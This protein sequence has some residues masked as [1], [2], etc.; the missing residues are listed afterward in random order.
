LL[1]ASSGA[2]AFC[3]IAAVTVLGPL[4]RSGEA[5]CGAP[6]CTQKREPAGF[7]LSQLVH[8]MGLAFLRQPI[9]A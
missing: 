4:A 9:R 8:C 2:A 3:A 7:S 6:Q 5:G 1:A